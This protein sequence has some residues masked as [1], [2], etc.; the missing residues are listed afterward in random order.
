MAEFKMVSRFRPT[1]PCSVRTQVNIVLF[2]RQRT[3]SKNVKKFF[4]TYLLNISFNSCSE[5]NWPRFATNNVE[6]GAALMLTVGCDGGVDPTG[7]A[8]AGDGKKCGGNEAACIA[9]NAAVGWG[10]DSGGCKKNA[11]EKRRLSFVGRGGHAAIPRL[12]KSFAYKTILQKWATELGGFTRRTEYRKLHVSRRIMERGNP[13]S[14]Y[15]STTWIS[16]DG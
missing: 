15:H 5:T 2:R 7:D 6:H 11:N 3:C 8:N 12:S 16:L 13:E 9:V 10:I 1:R 4:A 14:E